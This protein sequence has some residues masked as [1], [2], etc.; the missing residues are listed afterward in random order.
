MKLF[1]FNKS[2]HLYFDP[3][4]IKDVELLQR[5]RE[6]PNVRGSRPVTNWVRINKLEYSNFLSILSGK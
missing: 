6:A 5:L 4:I 1:L 3:K 2:N